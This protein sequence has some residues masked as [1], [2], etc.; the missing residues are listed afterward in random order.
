MFKNQNGFSPTKL[1]NSYIKMSKKE[2]AFLEENNGDG[3]VVI[4]D[5]FEIDPNFENKQENAE[6]ER[7]QGLFMTKLDFVQAIAPLGIT[8][9]HVKAMLEQ[10]PQAQMAWDLCNNIYRNNPLVEQFLASEAIGLTEA[11]ID[12]LFDGVDKMKHGEAAEN[13]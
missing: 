6:K 7:I 12:T 10:D 13:D 2:I 9:A 3:W 8:Y 1:D 4:D 5:M 11:Q